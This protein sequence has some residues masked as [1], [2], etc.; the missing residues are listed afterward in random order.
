VESIRQ[1]RALGGVTVIGSGGVRSGVDAAK[2]IAL[3]ADLAGIAQPF[4]RAAV[5]SSERVAE[6]LARTR[7]EL[8]IAMFC[9]G[10]RRPTDLREVDM[11]RRS[12]A[13]ARPPQHGG[14]KAR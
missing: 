4:L 1:L 7:R 3:G 8:E 12:G 14:G 2:A 5:E 10:C 13:D 6:A 9:C 11:A